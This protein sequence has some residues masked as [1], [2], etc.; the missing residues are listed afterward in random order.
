MSI[1]SIDDTSGQAAAEVFREARARL[2]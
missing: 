1:M 2:K